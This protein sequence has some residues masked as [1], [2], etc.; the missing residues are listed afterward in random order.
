MRATTKAPRNTRPCIGF[1][2]FTIPTRICYGD[3]LFY[4]EIKQLTLDLAASSFLGLPLGP[5]A[6]RINKAFIDMVAASVAVVRAPLP[7]TAMGRGVAGRRFLLD[8][9]MREVPLRREGRAR[10]CSVRCAAPPTKTGRRSI[11]SR[12]PTT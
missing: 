2:T 11:R 12:S 8:L 5:E 6:D 10:T 4:P 1:L 9:F 3:F 7:M